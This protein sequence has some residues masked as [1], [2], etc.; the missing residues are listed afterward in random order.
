MIW[1]RG[2][3]TGASHLFKRHNGAVWRRVLGRFP[4]RKPTIFV[5]SGFAPFADRLW[6]FEAAGFHVLPRFSMSMFRFVVASQL[7]LF[8]V[9]F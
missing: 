2:S 6:S 4:A 3:L 1:D 8:S 9:V 7:F 5:V